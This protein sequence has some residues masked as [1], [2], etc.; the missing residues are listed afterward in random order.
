L[1]SEQAT[2]QKYRH[3]KS[4]VK[5]RYT[6]Q[7]SNRIPTICIKRLTFEF[8]ARGE[9]SSDTESYAVRTL[10]TEDIYTLKGQVRSHLIIRKANS[11]GKLATRTIP[12]IEDLRQI[13]TNYYPLGV[14][15]RFV[16][17]GATL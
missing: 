6:E 8:Y 7:D 2:N 17:P 12:V 16:Q 3:A 4:R 11:K 15:R 13:L 14:N 9:M 10:L 1:T 5:S